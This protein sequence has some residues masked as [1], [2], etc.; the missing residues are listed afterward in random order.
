MFMKATTLFSRGIWKYIAG[1]LENAACR[2]YIKV[3]Y[4]RLSELLKII[5]AKSVKIPLFS[6]HNLNWVTGILG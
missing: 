3:R 2:A 5:E 4:V 6:A 1:A